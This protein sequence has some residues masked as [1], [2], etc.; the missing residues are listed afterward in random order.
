MVFWFQIFQRS[1]FSFFLF[2]AVNF[3]WL[4]THKKEEIDTK[5]LL[6]KIDTKLHFF[7]KKII[8][9]YLFHIIC[10]YIY[11]SFLLTK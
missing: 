11:I 2:L 5:L 7:G 8:L 4:I 6:K 1:S 10:I 9:I 3:D